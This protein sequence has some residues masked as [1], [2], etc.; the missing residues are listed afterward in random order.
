MEKIKAAIAAGIQ[1]GKCACGL[2]PEAQG[3]V[4]HLMAM[5][6]DLGDGDR[7]KGIERMRD[8]F[9]WVHKWRKT[10]KM[11]GA[12]VVRTITVAA[13]MAILALIGYKAV[14]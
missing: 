11:V 8:G 4:A 2:S 7:S 1:E 3:E 9:K 14:K 5:A 13:V 6:K 10:E 12:I